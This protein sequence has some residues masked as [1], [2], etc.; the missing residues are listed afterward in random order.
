MK[1]QQELQLHYWGPLYDMV[2]EY[3]AKHNCDVKP[4]ECVKLIVHGGE[5][6]NTYKCNPLLDCKTG[7][8]HFAL[9]ILY[10]DK[11]KEHRPVFAGDKLYYKRDGSMITIGSGG[12]LDNPDSWSWN[13]PEPKHELTGEILN[14]VCWKFVETYS[15][16]IDS[17]LFSNLKPVIREVLKEYDSITAARDKD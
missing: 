7:V 8:Y 5:W 9:T 13:P 3:N 2:K 14:Q 4:W 1:T 17:H 6:A 15:K 10:D 11:R 16:P 12:V